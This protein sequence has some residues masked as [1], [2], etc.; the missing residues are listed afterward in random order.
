MSEHKGPVQGS[1]RAALRCTRV[2]HDAKPKEIRPKVAPRKVAVVDKKTDVK[3]RGKS[4]GGFS[5]A[6]L[7]AGL[8]KL[9]SASKAKKEQSTGD[10][11]EDQEGYG[12]EFW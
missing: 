11:E 4:S 9:K 8:D 12:D 6:S 2:C 10:E 3:E 7:R 1:R 5:A